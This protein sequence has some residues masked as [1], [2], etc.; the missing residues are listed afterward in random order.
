MCELS[1]AS[2][3]A[4]AASSSPSSGL[5]MSTPK[6]LVLTCKPG[7][8]LR[9]LLVANGVNVYRSL[10]RWTNCSGKQLCGT[11]IV[12]VTEGLDRCSRRGLDEASTLRQN[13]QT[14][15][16]SC[17]TD[18]YGDVSVVVGG[19]VGAEQWTR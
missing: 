5:S 2:S 8:N 4:A 3:A 6:T 16:L 19:E 18:V 17:V 7:T 13:P 15:R 9:D 14:Y 1:A 12:E 10:S 11:C